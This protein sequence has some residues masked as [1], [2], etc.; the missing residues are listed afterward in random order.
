MIITINVDGQ[1]MFVIK[2]ND[3]FFA[4]FEFNESAKRGRLIKWEFDKAV[5]FSGYDE[6]DETD[7]EINRTMMVVE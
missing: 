7:C 5:L 3:K 4:G 6:A 2:R 1:T